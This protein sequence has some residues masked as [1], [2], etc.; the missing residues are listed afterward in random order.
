LL[1]PGTTAYFDKIAAAGVTATMAFE[2]C[3]TAG[4]MW[5]GGYD[6]SHAA[7]PM[8]YTPLLSTGDNAGFYAVSM[9]TIAL[10]ATDLG[11]TAASLD[12]PIIDTGTSLF[13][14]PSAAETNLIKAIN[15]DPAFKTLFPTQKL[16]DP[17]NSSSPTAGCV[18]AP[19]G[20]S[21]AMV[22]QQLP[23]L[24]MTFAGTGGSR[25]TLE[26]PA[27]ASYFYST[28]GGQYCL[29]V[30]GGG[31]HGNATLGDAFMRGF[32]TVIDVANQRIG[33]A[34]TMHCAVPQSGDSPHGHPRERGRGPH[35]FRP[36]T[37]D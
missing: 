8:Q 22:D 25:I 29:A 12:G 19:S 20:T 23:K 16:T 30:Y 31:D 11:A 17:T 4:T 1:D 24:A 21:D 15:A 2:L 27:L 14:I 18:N 32:I 37:A 28:G 10:G 36:S 3:P 6:A 35:H 13:Y 7:G 9:T 26:A 34:P 33:F 5:L